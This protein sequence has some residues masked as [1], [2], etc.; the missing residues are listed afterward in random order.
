MQRA[1]T[2][3]HAKD[4]IVADVAGNFDQSPPKDVET[5]LSEIASQL[6][7]IPVTM[8]GLNSQV[9][10]ATT[11]NMLPN[12]TVFGTSNYNA[13]FPKGGTLSDLSFLMALTG[14]EVN[15]SL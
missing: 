1:T 3:H 15:I 2:L 5:A 9:P 7:I 10:A 13:V 14:T 6:G 11:W 12:T 4:N 8:N